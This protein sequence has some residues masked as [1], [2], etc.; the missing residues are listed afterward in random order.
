MEFLKIQKDNLVLSVAAIDIPV[1]YEEKIIWKSNV[2][3]DINYNEYTTR[4]IGLVYFRHAELIKSAVE[5][6]NW[7]EEAGDKFS[8][9]ATFLFSDGIAIQFSK[10]AWNQLRT[11]IKNTQ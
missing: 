5:A 1:T 6:L 2:N 9:Q 8:E 10:S 4:V 11:S 3:S 7:V